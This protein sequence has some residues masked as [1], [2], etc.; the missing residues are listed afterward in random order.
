[1][2]D[3]WLGCDGW[4]FHF[5]NTGWSTWLWGRPRFSKIWRAANA[6]AE[7]PPADLRYLKKSKLATAASSE[8]RGD[9]TGFLHHIYASIAENLPDVRDGTI[10]EGEEDLESSVVELKSDPYQSAVSKSKIAKPR[11]F[12]RSMP[13]RDGSLE[14]RYLPP[15]TM[16]DYWTQYVRQSKLST[17]ASFP[18]FWRVS[19]MF[20]Y[21]MCRIFEFFPSVYVGKRMI[22]FKTSSVYL[23][24]SGM[25]IRFQCHE[26]SQGLIPHWVYRMYQTQECHSKPLTPLGGQKD[27]AGTFLQ[28]PWRSISR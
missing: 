26:V 16:K 18:V 11:K 10:E 27:P 24:D 15:G 23:L 9:V 17:P 28:A 21:S 22:P 3:N 19:L 6:G 14:P 7:G 20:D 2:T 4:G 12:F 1:M 13:I 25:G 8:L 5:M